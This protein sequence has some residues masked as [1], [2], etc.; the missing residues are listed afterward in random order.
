MSM[1]VQ[2]WNT[3]SLLH[4]IIFCT[5]KKVSQGKYNSCLQLRTEQEGHFVEQPVSRMTVD[6]LLTRCVFLVQQM[7]FCDK[8]VSVRWEY[9][10]ELIIF[11]FISNF[12]RSP[13]AT[14]MFDSAVLAS[15]SWNTW[16][17]SIALCEC[18]FCSC[19]VWEIPGPFD[20]MLWT[21]NN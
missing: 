14:M 13:I 18:F 3:I 17:T 16:R 20:T 7:Y 11:Q 5:K 2:T 1:H 10:Q 6:H 9:Q 15:L 21:W 4:Q 12:H 19:L 8:N